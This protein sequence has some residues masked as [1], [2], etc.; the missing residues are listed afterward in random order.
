MVAAARR[1]HAL[2]VEAARR[3]PAYFAGFVL[4]DEQT[5]EPITL[6]ASHRRW[7]QLLLKHKELVI[8]GHQESGKTHQVGIAHV[9]WRLGHNPNLKIAIVSKTTEQAKKILGAIRQYIESSRELHEVFPRMRL[10]RDRRMKNNEK[11]LT[12]ERDVIAKDPSVQ[13]TG[14]KGNIVG[15]RVDILYVD[16]LLDEH[17]TRT[18]APR[19][20][21]WKWL[22]GNGCFGRVTKFGLIWV[23]TNAWHPQD[24]N[25]R[26]V[27]EAGFYGERFPILFPDKLPDGSPHPQAGTSTWPE[28]W[29]EWR[30][31]RMRD[32]I[33]GVVEFTRAM[34]CRPR[35]ETSAPI[36]AEWV[37]AALRRGEG[38]RLVSSFAE[39]DY[40]ALKG[41]VAVYTGVDLAIQKHDSADLTVRATIGVYEDG[42]RRVLSLYG[43]RMGAP[44]IL[45][46]ITQTHA[47][48]PPGVF[49]VENVA[50]QHYL[51]QILNAST[52]IPIIPFTTGSG[53]VSS[54]L[55]D[56]GISKLGLEL[57][58]GKWVF[59][60]PGAISE[61]SG[62]WIP[63]EVGQHMRALVS[64]LIEYD[65]SAHP[66]DYL[67]ALWFARE[68]ACGYGR[69]TAQVGVETMAET[70]EERA[71]REEREAFEQR[72]RRRAG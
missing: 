22:R 63:G 8:W 12:L 69:P 40:A 25:E 30:I 47:N 20:T 42:T 37:T 13:V 6:A 61:A 15:S 29:P 33:L 68:G 26:L 65:P 49:V 45:S 39:L 23:T 7:H 16:D 58:Q 72:R 41:L 66:S 5:N 4:R 70:P 52:A 2:R 18:Q 11:F 19:E 55:S 67:M 46:M 62:L 35:D 53:K 59:P 64:G 38:L 3:D 48:F 31:A 56:F 28:R 50:A 71:D 36:R 32:R 21:T 10:S 43:D 27:R 14:E 44:E 51:I 1:A 17:N 24:C 54:A 60:C 34:L 57:E 9:L